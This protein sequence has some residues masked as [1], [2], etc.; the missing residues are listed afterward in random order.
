MQP[1]GITDNKVLEPSVF[2]KVPLAAGPNIE[3]VGAI[4]AAPY[5]ACFL[6][7]KHIEV[8]FLFLFGSISG[9]LST[10]CCSVTALR[11]ACS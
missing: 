3:I 10:F 5:A 8:L 2:G 6:F 9:T 4:E 11:L 1:T 7:P